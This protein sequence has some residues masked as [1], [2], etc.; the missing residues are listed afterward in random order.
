MQ[1]LSGFPPNIEKI[2][3]VFPDIAPRAV[4]TYGDTMF[5]QD[6]KPVEV[7]EHLVQHEMTHTLQQ[8]EYPEVWW[9]KYLSD[10]EFRLSQE[11]EAYGR[12]YR[13]I[14]DRTL[15]KYAK[16]ALMMLAIDLSGPM[17]GNLLTFGE[18]ETKIRRAAK[19]AL[20]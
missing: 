13:Y 6:T 2:R 9:N 18:A 20:V 7:A 14:Y 10:V 15:N 16:E 3:S 17:Y 19:N 4:F 5:I 12:Q 11:I 8:G 1:L